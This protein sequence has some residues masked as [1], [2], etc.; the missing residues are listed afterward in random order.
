MSVQN[1]KR[2]TFDIFTRIKRGDNLT[3]IG[4]V[5]AETEELATVYATFTYDEEDWVEM[6]VVQR[7]HL[8]WVRK[9]EGLFAKEGA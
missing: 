8:N 3:H 6:C 7:N 9:P 2:L 5:E 1:E 4:T